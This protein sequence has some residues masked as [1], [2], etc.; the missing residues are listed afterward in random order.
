MNMLLLFTHSQCYAKT[1]QTI[2]KMYIFVSST[3]EIK[4]YRFGIKWTQMGELS[5]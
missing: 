2:F 1:F 5:L 3:E 4:Y